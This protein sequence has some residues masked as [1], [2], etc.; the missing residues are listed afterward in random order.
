MSSSNEALAIFGKWKREQT[1][2]NL[3]VLAPDEVVEPSMV[4]LD[5][6]I[7]DA[8][9]SQVRWV[10]GTES[11]SRSLSNVSGFTAAP[12]GT[13]LEISFSDRTRLVFVER[14]KSA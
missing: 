5:V 1:S 14:G 8:D 13:S 7:S 9:P 12:D 11:L 2:L 4:A 3:I 6:L 10:I